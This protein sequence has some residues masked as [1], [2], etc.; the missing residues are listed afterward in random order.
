MNNNIQEIYCWK[1]GTKFKW[2]D[3]LVFNVVDGEKFI[4]KYQDSLSCHSK[5]CSKCVKEVFNI[6]DKYGYVMVWYTGGFAYQ[7]PKE[8]LYDEDYTTLKEYGFIDDYYK[9]KEGCIRLISPSDVYPYK[10]TTVLNDFE[11]IK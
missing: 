1:C 6:L 8:L 10:N 2:E 7:L 5:T 3:T 4:Q 11:T 9:H